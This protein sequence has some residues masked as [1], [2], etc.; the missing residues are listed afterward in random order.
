MIKNPSKLSD[1]AKDRGLTTHWKC[2]EKKSLFSE[3]AA[4]IEICKRIE[5]LEE[6][7]HSRSPLDAI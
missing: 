5:D 3:M 2:W 1:F 7:S 6:D 4:L